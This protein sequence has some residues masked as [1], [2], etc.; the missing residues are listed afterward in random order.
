MIAAENT[1]GQSLQLLFSTKVQLFV[2]KDK[3]KGKISLH[4]RRKYG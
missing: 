3:Q 2:V 1:L 4:R